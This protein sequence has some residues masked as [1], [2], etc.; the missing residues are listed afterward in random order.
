M[1]ATATQPR[2][3]IGL[4]DPITFGE[5]AQLPAVIR[6]GLSRQ[7]LYRRYEAGKL[8]CETLDGTHYTTR[9]HV[10][11]LIDSEKQA[12]LALKQKLAASPAG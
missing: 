1:A 11:S 9:R 2:K 7:A 4:D 3:R 6:H 8:K 5:A 12:A 10:Q